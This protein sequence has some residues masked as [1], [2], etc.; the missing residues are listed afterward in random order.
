MVRGQWL[1]LLAFVGCAPRAVDDKVPAQEDR[2]ASVVP[3]A[4]PATVPSAPRPEPRTPIAGCFVRGLAACD[5]VSN[6]GCTSGET[7]DLVEDEVELV[8]GC[9]RMSEERPSSSLGQSCSIA[10]GTRCGAGLRCASG[11]CRSYCCSDTDCRVAGERCLALDVRLGTLGTCGTPP[12]CKRSGE[13]CR[14]AA[15]CCSKDCHFNH[16]H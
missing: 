16:C 8:L 7:C 10:S 14:L 4:A 6:A 1:L 3:D 13:A 2:D 5:P 15:D 11:T 9:E 12:L